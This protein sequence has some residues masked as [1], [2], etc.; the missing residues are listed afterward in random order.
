MLT[1]PAHSDYF[2]A[3]K[4][5]PMTIRVKKWGI[6]PVRMPVY[7]LDSLLEQM[8]P[9]TF[10]EDIDFGSPMGREVW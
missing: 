1:Y 9:D 6:E 7:D 5:M 4:A 2:G 8:S 3:L 10:P